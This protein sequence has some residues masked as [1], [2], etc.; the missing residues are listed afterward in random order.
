[1]LL[2]MALLGYSGF[3]EHPQYPTW[4]RDLTTSIWC[5]K[6][7]KLLRRL[8][9]VTAV[10][11]DQ[12]ICGAVRRKPTMLLLVRLPNVRQQL[13]ALG[14]GGRCAHP[15]GTHQA[16]IGK[17]ED[18]S[19]QTA[20][21]K[22]YPYKMNMSLEQA[23]YSFATGF[24]QCEVEPGLPHQFAPYTEQFFIWII[25][26]FKRIITGDH[27]AGALHCL[28]ETKCHSGIARAMENGVETTNQI[29]ND[30]F[31][32]R[33]LTL[34]HWFSAVNIHLMVINNTSDSARCV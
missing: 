4:E 24:L 33:F 7:T 31:F 13:L 1:M 6:A 17:E 5:L 14:R 25:P 22:I 34:L 2:T 12:C 27:A 10:S 16:L 21:A 29:T 18:G 3:V 20:K 11:F 30:L 23:M 8:H 15:A 9:C 32:P 28:Q 19:F 26:R